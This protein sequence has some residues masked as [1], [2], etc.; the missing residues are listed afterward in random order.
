MGLYTMPSPSSRWRLAFRLP[1]LLYASPHNPGAAAAARVLQA[2]MHGNFDVTTDPRAFPVAK[3]LRQRL[4]KRALD[5]LEDGG[6]FCTAPWATF[7]DRTFTDKLVTR[8]A[9]GLASAIFS[10]A[11]LDVTTL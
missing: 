1:V 9:T 3:S 11:R 7:D 4:T 10:V 2:G 8:L 6:R 5:A